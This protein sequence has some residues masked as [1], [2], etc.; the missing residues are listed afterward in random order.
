VPGQTF[1]LSGCQP[2]LRLCSN[3]WNRWPQSSS[4]RN[5]RRLNIYR[6]RTV[7]PIAANG[8]EEASTLPVGRS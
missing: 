1:N 4:G 6:C 5:E 2:I 7:L 3:G 8:S